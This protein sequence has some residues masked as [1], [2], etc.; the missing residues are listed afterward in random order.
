MA[1]CQETGDRKFYRLVLAYYDF[2]NLAREGINVVR[3][4]AIICGNKALRKPDMPEMDSMAL[5]VFDS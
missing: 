1:A 4:C 3:H 5:A 2:T